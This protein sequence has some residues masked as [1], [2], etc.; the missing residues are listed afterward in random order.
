MA[1]KRTYP[2]EEEGDKTEDLLRAIEIAGHDRVKAVLRDVCLGSKAAFE[3]AS[4]KLLVAEVLSSSEEEGE[5]S[6]S[7][8]SEGSESEESEVGLTAYG[9]L[10]RKQVEA[11]NGKRLRYLFCIQCKGEF[12]TSFNDPEAC[13]WHDGMHT[14]RT[15]RSFAKAAQ[16]TLSLSMI[17]S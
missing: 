12:D 1:K 6:E 2:N 14:E 9:D 16:G 5:G 17:A 10:N 4:S 3:L 11:I 15:C 7:E 8:G 13:R